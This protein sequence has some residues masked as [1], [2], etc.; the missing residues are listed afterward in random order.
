MPDYQLIFN[1]I[2]G[3]YMQCT[4]IWRD[5]TSHIV[6]SYVHFEFMHNLNDWGF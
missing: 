1:S 4:P 6:L 5:N 2:M 3:F